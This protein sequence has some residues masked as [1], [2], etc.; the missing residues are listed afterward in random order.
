MGAR[1]MRRRRRHED[2]MRLLRRAVVE[3][4]THAPRGSVEERVALFERLC[5]ALE[6]APVLVRGRAP[7]E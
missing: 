7:A 6:L 3:L 2:G 1:V 4:E 5:D